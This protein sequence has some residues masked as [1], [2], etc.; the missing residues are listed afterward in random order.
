[1]N[2]LCVR[3]C[4]FCSSIEEICKKKYYFFLTGDIE[5][6]VFALKNKQ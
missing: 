4:K 5:I 2:D 6:I 1:M 3:I